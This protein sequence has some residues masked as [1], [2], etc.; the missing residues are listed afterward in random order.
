MGSFLDSYFSLD[1]VTE[2]PL[3]LTS[4]TAELMG[5]YS[6]ARVL[7]HGTCGPS[8]KIS[9]AVPCWSRERWSREHRSRKRHWR[10]AEPTNDYS[11]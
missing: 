5:F 3:G 9:M 6:V 10:R 1:V 2:S 11:L 7:S 8:R 4:Q